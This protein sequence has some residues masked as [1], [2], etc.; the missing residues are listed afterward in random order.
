[1]TRYTGSALFIAQLVFLTVAASAYEIETHALISEF[2]GP[3]SQADDILKNHLGVNEGLSRIAQG[4]SLGFWLGEG[5]KRED[6]VLRLLN[7][8]H[9]PLASGWSQAGLLASIGQSSVV[10]AQNTGQ[11]FPGWSWADVRQRYF[12][13]LTKLQ[14]PERDSGLA[15]TFEGLGRQIHLI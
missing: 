6:N 1:M 15:K 9:N 5:S 13:A 14:L 4:F 10:W 12:D 11:G 2:A 7:H 3:R 8:F